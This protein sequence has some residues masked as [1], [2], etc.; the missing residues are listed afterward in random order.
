M[1]R[2]AAPGDHYLGRGLVSRPGADSH[3]EIGVSALCPRQKE[4]SSPKGSDA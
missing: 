4:M 2:L 1:V 3:R